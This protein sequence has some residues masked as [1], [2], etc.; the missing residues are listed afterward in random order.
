MEDGGWSSGQET[1]T[2]SRKPDK[3]GL[4]PL[5]VVIS[6]RNRASHME[7]SV[8]MGIVDEFSDG[9]NVRL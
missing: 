3:E 9:A 2:R 5:T 4:W 7:C 6:P 8:P 1:T